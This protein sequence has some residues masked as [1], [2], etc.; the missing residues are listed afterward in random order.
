M[1]MYRSEFS[2]VDYLEDLNYVFFYLGKVVFRFRRIEEIAH[3]V[4]PN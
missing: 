4:I 3:G 2:D 1:I